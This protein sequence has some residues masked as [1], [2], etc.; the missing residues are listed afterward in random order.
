VSIFSPNFYS[1]LLIRLAAD[2]KLTR[3]HAFFMIM[4]GFHYFEGSDK[5]GASATR[6]TH[7]DIKM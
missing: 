2:L 6:F 7:L 4:G 5:T 3:T 1:F